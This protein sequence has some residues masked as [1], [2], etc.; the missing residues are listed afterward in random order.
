[1]E[2]DRNLAQI[3]AVATPAFL[4]LLKVL[5]ATGARPGELANATAANFDAQKGAII[6]LPDAIRPPGLYRHKNAGRGK[7]RIILLTGEALDIVKKLVAKH[8][9]GP[10]FR[11]SRPLR[12]ERKGLPSKWTPEVIVQRFFKIRKAMGL[13]GVTA[14]SF[15]HQF[16]TDWIKDGK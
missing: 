3:F 2:R 13:S 6:H 14:Y 11:T 8:P 5:A 9:T 4:P 12:G 7:T 1:E 15:R 10:L 16:C